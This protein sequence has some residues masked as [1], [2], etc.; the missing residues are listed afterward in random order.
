[1]KDKK[2]QIGIEQ[3]KKVTMTTSEKRRILEEVLGSSILDSAL[4][5]SPYTFYSFVSNLKKN[6][7]FS[8]AIISCLVIFLGSG[9]VFASEGSLPDNI[10]YPLKVNIVEPIR[11]ALITS[12]VDKA[13]Y[14]SSLATKRL[15]EAETLAKQ[16]KLDVSKE[17]KLNKLLSKHTNA[18]NNAINEV[19]KT[20]SV[21]V[22]NDIINNFHAKM[23]TQAEVLN[24]IS[25]RENNPDRK[26]QYNQIS[27]SVRSNADKVRGISK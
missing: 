15:S 5:R 4:V 10:L 2:L 21:G 7:F 12:P 3:I 9:V 11:A 1:M 20:K 8:Y 25:N 23:N 6:R 22:A 18:L 27:K 19:S 14:E 16:G 26:N 24:N 13:Q 17:N